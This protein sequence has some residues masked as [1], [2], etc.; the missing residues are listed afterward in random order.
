MSGLWRWWL[1]NGGCG[2]G[3]EACGVAVGFAGCRVPWTELTLT[4]KA[5]GGLMEEQ[6]RSHLGR[7]HCVVGEQGKNTLE[8]WQDS[9]RGNSYLVHSDPLGPGEGT[10]GLGRNLSA[11][12]LIRPAEPFVFYVL[13]PQSAVTTETKHQGAL[14]Y[15]QAWGRLLGPLNN[16]FELGKGNLVKSKTEF[17]TI[18]TRWKIGK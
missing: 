15:G 10:S 8:R 13:P 17:L 2:W 11:P 4:R 1:R 18:T 5:D 9:W 6:G 12:L 14:I 7:W 3:I 16:P